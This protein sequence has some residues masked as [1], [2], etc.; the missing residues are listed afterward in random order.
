MSTQGNP[1]E[2]KDEIVELLSALV[3]RWPIV[4]ICCVICTVGAWVLAEY[5]RPKYRADALIQIDTAASSSKSPMNLS[6]LFGETSQTETEIEL[7]NS[8]SVIGTVVEALGLSM[9]AKPVG[10]LDRLLHREGR[11]ELS[12]LDIPANMFLEPKEKSMP[13]FIEATDSAHFNVLDFNERRAYENCEVGKDYKFTYT[14]TAGTDTVRVALKSMSAAE[15]QK[16]AVR[17]L[18]RLDAIARFEKSFEVSERG[19]KTGVLEFTYEDVYSD[20]AAYVV[21]EVARAYQ[22]NNV[23]L[24][25]LEAASTIKFLES[26]L[27]VVRT[28][29]DSAEQEL[30]KYRSQSGTI[31]VN[32]EMKLILETQKDLNEQL[33]NLEQK[34]TETVRL[35]HEEHPTVKTLDEQIAK[36]RKEMRSSYSTVKDMPEKKQ[37]MMKLSNDVE[38]TKMLY[39]NMLNNIQQLQLV[40]AGEVGSVRIIDF[41]EP[42]LDPVSPKKT[43]IRIAGFLFGLC[44]SVLICHLLR[45]FF[46]NGVKSSR[47]IENELGVSVYAK[48][49]KDAGEKKNPS[50]IP[51][52]AYDPSSTTV[53][54]LR[55][56]RSSLEFALPEGKTSVVVVTGLTPGVGKSF[57]SSNLAAL[58]AC[59]E[60]RKVILVDA[61]IRK[62]RLHKEFG[63]ERGNGLSEVLLG[64][65]SFEESVHKTGVEGLDI[66]SCGKVST[67]PAELFNSKQFKEFISKLR[68]LYD[69]I[70]I[71]TPPIMFV[72][73][74]MLIARYM[75]H[76]IMVVEYGKHKMEAIKEGM[77]MF[78]KGAGDAHS[79]IVMNKYVHSR[80]EGYGYKY[81]KY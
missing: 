45:I 64:S 46:D 80:Q 38:L 55:T 17:K 18:R 69:L 29:M 62:G 26:Q 78:I 72:T 66:L 77:T 28:R 76:G 53:E 65:I 25:S 14:G 34:R 37:E 81:G 2:E 35:F 67:N 36:L 12:E 56:L 68:S 31:D 50:H 32:A 4:V 57:V 48:I 30:N 49:P 15:G 5:I 54:A 61:D 7:I 20:R 44:L 10:R 59:T 3:E 21:N 71:D 9:D 73:D 40:S 27:P 52:A 1:S 13:W 74:A 11:I 79:A 47:L 16:F 60:G 42:T 19:K 23:A 33:L 58:F 75:D 63:V 70:V 41:A 43:L 22:R 24:R 39:T 51:L 8:R 6:S